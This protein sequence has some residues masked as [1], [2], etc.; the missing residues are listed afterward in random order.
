MTWHGPPPGAASAPAIATRHLNQCSCPHRQAGW[1]PVPLMCTWQR[2]QAGACVFLRVAGLSVRQRSAGFKDAVSAAQ[3]DTWAPMFPLAV[4]VVLPRNKQ[5]E[6]VSTRKHAQPHSK[7]C[8]VLGT[9]ALHLT[10]RDASQMSPALQAK[11]P[12]L[13]MM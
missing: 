7:Q 12:C 10:A 9:A 3:M 5:V 13:L 1:Q 2:R 8:S 4:G 6:Q 11:T